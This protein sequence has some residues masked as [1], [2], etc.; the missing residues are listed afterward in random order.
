MLQLGGDRI[1]NHRMFLKI[2]VTFCMKFELVRRFTGLPRDT[3]VDFLSMN[4]S[5]SLPEDEHLSVCADIELVNLSKLVVLFFLYLMV[6]LDLLPLVS[7]KLR[8]LD[9][10]DD[11]VE[12]SWKKK[13]IFSIL[14]ILE[15]THTEA[16]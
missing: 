16:S 3:M 7:L 15:G 8:L 9:T 2:D 10:W 5:S 11:V 12:V 13:T 1:G 6:G 4:C 14:V